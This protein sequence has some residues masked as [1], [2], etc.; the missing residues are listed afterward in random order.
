MVTKGTDMQGQ[1]QTWDELNPQPGDKIYFHIPSLMKGEIRTVTDHPYKTDIL[2]EQKLINRLR[3]NTTDPYWYMFKRASEK[4]KADG[5]ETMKFER[6]PQSS[7]E[8]PALYGYINSKNKVDWALDSADLMELSPMGDGTN[9]YQ[10][11]REGDAI[12]GCATCWYHPKGEFQVKATD[13]T[14][15]EFVKKLEEASDLFGSE[16]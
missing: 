3:A 7:S 9:T 13:L 11:W 14:P 12:V 4:K 6:L 8:K 10:I 2:D 16:M 15:E 5:V 1:G